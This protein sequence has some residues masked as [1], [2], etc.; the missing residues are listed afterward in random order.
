TIVAQGPPGEVLQPRTLQ[1]VYG[2][3]CDVVECAS[4][5]IPWCVARGRSLWR[6][7]ELAAETGENGGERGDGSLPEDGPAGRRARPGGPA[8]GRAARARPRRGDRAPRVAPRTRR[9]RG[10]PAA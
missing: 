4:S 6:M 3:E 2:V 8:V 1:Q 10:E 7:L 9:H 5:G